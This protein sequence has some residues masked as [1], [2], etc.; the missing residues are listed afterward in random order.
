MFGLRRAPRAPD[1]AAILATSR[2]EVE[3]AS[4]VS[5]VRQGDRTV[6][7]DYRTGAYHSLDEVGSRVWESLQARVPWPE[8]ADRLSE[9]YAVPAA[10][11]RADVAALL[12]SLAKLRLVRVSFD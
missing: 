9:E 4:E 6:L 10:R 3:V 7:L 11:V 2:A 8:L 1:A 5:S 12:E